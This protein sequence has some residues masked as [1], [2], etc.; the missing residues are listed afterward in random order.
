VH[1]AVLCI[2]VASG[3]SGGDSTAPGELSVP[4]TLATTAD[5]GAAQKFFPLRLENIGGGPVTITGADFTGAFSLLDPLPVVINAGETGAVTVRAPL[6]E[7]GTDRGGDHKAG[8]LVLI[9]DEGTHEVALTNDVIGA[10]LDLM[11]ST[12]QEFPRVAFT[13]AQCPTPITITFHNTGNAPLTFDTGTPTQFRFT[14]PASTTLAAGASAAV[15]VRP[16]TTSACTGSENLS[17]T[18]TGKVCSAV[19]IVVPATFELTG[20]P[21]CSCM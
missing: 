6:A 15:M 17:I 11:T 1:R 21:T 14:N 8:T 13:G 12:S 3:C 20:T 10:T 2:F 18:A 16:Y 5:C 4:A 7:I 19:P 9:T